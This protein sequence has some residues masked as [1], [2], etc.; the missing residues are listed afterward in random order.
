M[1]YITVVP[2]IRTIPGVEEFDYA[3]SDGHGLL[4]GDLILVPFRKHAIPA[5]VTKFSDASAFAA[6][7][8]HL[9][10][11][12]PL[13]HFGEPLPALLRS[14]AQQTFSSQPTVLA[15]WVRTVPKRAAS[16]SEP[17][18]SRQTGMPRRERRFLADRWTGPNGLIETARTTQGKT[19]IVTPWQH[20]ADA[21]AKILGCPALHAD[22]AMGKAWMILSGFVDGSA[23]VLVTTRLGAWLTLQADTVLV[24]EPENDD[25][26]QDEL[27]PRFDA[28]LVVQECAKLQPDL[29]VISFNTTPRLN[30]EPAAWKQAPEISLSLRTEPKLMRGSSTIRDL[31][32]QT[33][34]DIE[35][36]IEEQRHVTIIHPIRGE[37]ARIACRDCGWTAT[38]VACSFPLSLVNGQALCRRCGRKNKIPVVCPSCGGSDLSRGRAGADQLMKQLESRFQSPLIRV[39]DVWEI[40]QISIAPKSLVVLTDVSLI[41][42]AIE[43]IRR[44]ERLLIAWRRLAA[45]LARLETQVVVQG[46]EDTV[47]DCT[48]WLTADGVERAWQKETSERKTFGYPPATRLIKLLVDG[49]EPMALELQRDL[50]TV[51]PAAMTL[52]GPFLVAFRAKSRG[53]RFV[54]H[55]TAAKE[56]PDDE[57]IALLDRF[58]KR[59]IIDLDPIAFFS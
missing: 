25:F 4:L 28:R 54:I 51:L 9:G 36:A 2:A 40:Q 15:S 45:S 5:L 41:G 19:L 47:T 17:K 6:R 23:P 30:A 21:L 48:D 8:V 59:A 12:Q 56:T 57:L 53:E 50:E 58:K 13:A 39:V 29:Y 52:R 33:I 35:Q 46:P 31:S 14:V 32:E 24:D 3:V 38:C 34:A 7:A 22:V 43:D 44:R 11:T 49:N 27:A 1:K 10:P 20:R 55:L 16:K 37:R 26:K 18:N 42:G